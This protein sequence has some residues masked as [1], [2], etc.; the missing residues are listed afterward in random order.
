MFKNDYYWFIG[1]LNTGYCFVLKIS[2]TRR[3]VYNCP[4][5]TKMWGM[6][7]P[8]K[9]PMFVG[10]TNLNVP[11]MIKIDET[12]FSTSLNYQI[13]NIN[14]NYMSF[15]SS[16][17]DDSNLM[18]SFSLTS[19]SS[20]YVTY[21]NTNSS[22]FTWTKKYNYQLS[23][24]VLQYSVVFDEYFILAKDT[25]NNRI[26]F[27]RFDYSDGGITFYKCNANNSLV[28]YKVYTT[29]LHVD[30]GSSIYFGGQLN[31]ENFF[32]YRTGVELGD[33]SCI[34]Q[35]S[36]VY[37]DTYYSTTNFDIS[38]KNQSFTLTSDLSKH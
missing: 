3:Y 29:S 23:Q 34:F 27:I 31:N 17:Q 2:S 4:A 19:D 20:L 12:S 37:P 7:I 24:P 32:M 30:A 1:Y 9:S 14:S 18:W 8:D 6:L 10:N 5:N 25:V 13:N 26:C 35:G 15:K 28:A 21:F 16:S 36:V 11:F 33:N 22:S 38:F